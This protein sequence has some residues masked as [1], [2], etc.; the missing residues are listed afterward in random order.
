VCYAAV[1]AAKLNSLEKSLAT[2]KVKRKRT[3]CAEEE[4]VGGGGGTLNRNGGALCI[5]K[6][7]VS[8]IAA[9]FGPRRR[10]SQENE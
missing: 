2:K 9:V 4:T 6:E 10:I 7:S 5:L 8:Q 1:L 3:H